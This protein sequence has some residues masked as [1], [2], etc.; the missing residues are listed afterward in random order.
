MHK[1]EKSERHEKERQVAL[2]ERPTAKELPALSLLD[3]PPARQAGYSAEALEAMSRLVELKLRDFDVEAEVVE[4]H[5]GPVIT[6]FGAPGAGR[7]GQPDLQPRQGPRARCLRSACA[8]S[9]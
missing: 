1:V 5:P 4:V 7:Q 8:S 3:D 2:F 9:K 6:R